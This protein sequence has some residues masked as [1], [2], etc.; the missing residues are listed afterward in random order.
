VPSPAASSN[1][2]KLWGRD[3][4][5]RQLARW[6][7]PKSWAERVR[8]LDLA[9]R[10]GH[11]RGVVGAW[12]GAR[13]AAERKHAGISAD[14]TERERREREEGQTRIPNPAPEPD[15]EQDLDEGR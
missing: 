2:S 7:N 5:E 8:A 4:I 12:Y 15:D 3:A 14:Q 10:V 1:E 6:W 13:D 9:Q 11:E